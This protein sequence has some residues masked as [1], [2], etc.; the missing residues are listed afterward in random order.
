MTGRQLVSIG[1]FKHPNDLAASS[2]ATPAQIAA[3]L[4]LDP[5]ASRSIAQGPPST[6]LFP[7]LE[8]L[9]PAA[10]RPGLWKA[11]ARLLVEAYDSPIS[12]IRGVPPELENALERL[13]AGKRLL[14]FSL[15]E[16]NEGNAE[17]TLHWLRQA[18]AVAGDDPEIQHY[19][20]QVQAEVAGNR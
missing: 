6:D 1:D 5:G 8:F 3:L 12:S 15:L 10:Y 2:L 14:L 7:H 20:R 17:G 9:A 11:N 19:A 13:V 4:L 18:L 16:R